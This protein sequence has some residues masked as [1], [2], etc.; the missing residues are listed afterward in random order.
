VEETTYSFGYWIQRRRKALDLSRASLAARV[1]CSPETIKKIERDERRPSEQ[2]AERLASALALSSHERASFLEIAQK[3]K[4]VDSLPFSLKPIEQLPA[5]IHNNLPAIPTPFLGRDTEVADILSRLSDEGCRLLT[6]AGPGGIGKTRL[7][8][9]VA[10][11][12]LDAYQ[13]GVCMVP[14][15]GIE[16]T[17]ALPAA[18]AAG[19]GLS[20]SVKTELLSNLLGYL[21]HKQ[22]LLVLDNFEHLLPDTRLLIEIL[23]NSPDVKILVTSR[24][25][26]NLNSEWVYLLQGLSVPPEDDHSDLLAYSS[27]NLFLQIARHAKPNFELYDMNSATVAQICRRVEGMPLAIQLAASWIPVMGPEGIAEEIRHGLDFLEADMNDLPERQRSMRAVFESSWKLLDEEE[28]QA[29]KMLAVFRG[30]FSL[31]SVHDIFQIPTKYILSLVNKC[32]VQPEAGGRFDLHELVRQYAQAKLQSDLE[33][34]YSVEER[35]SAHYCAVLSKHEENWFTEREGE[36]FREIDAEFQNIDAA[37][38]WSLKQQRLDLVVSASESLAR[39]YNRYLRFGEEFIAM[40]AALKCMDSIRNKHGKESNTVLLARARAM[41]S[42]IGQLTTREEIRAEFDKVRILLTQLEKD[43]VQTAPESARILAWEGHLMMKE[44]TREAF[45]LLRQ[46]A[47]LHNEMGNHILEAATFYSIGEKY[48]NLGDYDQAFYYINQCLQISK[49]TGYPRLLADC[50][51][52]LGILNRHTGNIEEAEKFGHSSLIEYRKQGLRYDD[53]FALLH[54][55]YTLMLAGKLTEAMLHA[56]H[57]LHVFNRLGTGPD[58]QGAS[59]IMI[60]LLMLH[61]GQ[62]EQVDHRI[63]N[64]LNELNNI[65][66]SRVKGL[67]WDTAGAYLLLT[68]EEEQAIEHFQMSRQIYQKGNLVSMAGTSQAYLAYAFLA[69]N[70]LSKGEQHLTRCLLEAVQIGSY[71]FAI[72]ALPALALYEADRGNT[73]RAIELY[74]LALK[75]PYVSES[76]WFDDIAGKRIK[77]LEAKISLEAAEAARIRGKSLELWDVVTGIADK[78]GNTIESHSLSD[79]SLRL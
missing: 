11:E 14:L 54:L 10:E 21:R 34:L 47:A 45:K 30:G 6:I 78:T 56:Q 67:I 18:I 2:I 52:L 74:E 13:H 19:L 59:S 20:H 44:D 69:L 31:A 49:R 35:H 76:N 43:G 66:D 26:L 4:P 50:H 7:S 15:A 32:W 65:T 5:S 46:A 62:Y 79:G 39:Y 55:S 58:H 27:I 1:N 17:A 12:A 61:Q 8:I 77:S 42:L 63:R 40:S 24:Q 68:H 48:T 41:I 23:Q 9:K 37:W 72:Q 33:Y 70:Q 64:S 36:A 38:K 75:H 51:M 25:R 73:I 53:G 71:L 60:T 22:L 28:Q 16:S 29:M 3:H 57:S